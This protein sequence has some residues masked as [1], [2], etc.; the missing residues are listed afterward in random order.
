SAAQEL[1]AALRLLAQASG[2]RLLD[3]AP[4]RTRTRKPEGERVSDRE[5]PIAVTRVRIEAR[6]T[7]GLLD[8]ERTPMPAPS[9]S[10]SGTVLS[11]WKAS[12]SVA[13]RALAWR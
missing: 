9:S 12:R 8:V 4:R 5:P 13:R 7:P 6:P 11:F 3:G 1:S 2:A 10:T